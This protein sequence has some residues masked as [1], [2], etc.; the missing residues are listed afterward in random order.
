[1]ANLYYND[2]TFETIPDLGSEENIK[3]IFI[4]MHH[5]TSANRGDVGADSAYAGEELLALAFYP[6]IFKDVYTT[7]LG[8]TEEQADF[9]LSTVEEAMMNNPEDYFNAV[10]ENS[11]ANVYTTSEF[12][13]VNSRESMQGNVPEETDAQAKKYEAIRGYILGKVESYDT[14]EAKHRYIDE[15]VIDAGSLG[16]IKISDIISDRPELQQ[17]INA[18][19]LAS[20]IEISKDPNAPE[21]FT[22]SK[23]VSNNAILKL[24]DTIDK[25]EQVIEEKY[26]G[27]EGY[28]EMHAH[29]IGKEKEKESLRAQKK[30]LL[31]SLNN[32]RKDWDERSAHTIISG[33]A[34]P[35]TQVF[36]GWTDWF[37][38]EGQERIEN[39]MF[40]FAH[41]A[42]GNTISYGDEV[43][44]QISS[45]QASLYDVQDRLV[46]LNVKDE[47]YQGLKELDQQQSK[48][49]NAIATTLIDDLILHGYSTEEEIRTLLGE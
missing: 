7:E 38:G 15:T 12:S 8:Y 47:L 41:D 28:E 24:L 18:H 25:N 39:R 46:E 45:I 5:K 19:M 11:V 1:M 33:L 17:E 36:A 32:L 44:P 20:A 16:K 23:E 48:N 40:K 31:S 30:E 35:I 13:E 43:G 4:N 2:P 21:T 26:G 27:Q 29:I 49:L 9:A 3:N 10:N 42:E 22:F 14:Y 34:V 37:R 6:N